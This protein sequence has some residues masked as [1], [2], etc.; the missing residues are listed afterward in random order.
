MTAVKNPHPAFPQRAPIHPE[1]ENRS[2]PT[3]TLYRL[4]HRF[5][6]VPPKD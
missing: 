6:G 5:Y 2:V 4:K 1:S 3:V